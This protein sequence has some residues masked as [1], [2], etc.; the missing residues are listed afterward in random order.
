MARKNY[1]QLKRQ[2]EELRKNRRLSKLDRRTQKSPE[3]AAAAAEGSPADASVPSG[4][5]ALE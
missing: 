2:K 5:R 3:E 4:G 1:Q